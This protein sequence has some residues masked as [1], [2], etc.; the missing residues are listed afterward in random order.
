MT[1]VRIKYAMIMPSLA[2]T[3]ADILVGGGAFMDSWKERP[4]SG[5]KEDN[6]ERNT[7]TSLNLSL[8][9]QLRQ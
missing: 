1:Q 2:L 6:S 4:W 3:G 8:V 9:E 5:F 7:S